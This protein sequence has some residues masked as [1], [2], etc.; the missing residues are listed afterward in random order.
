MVSSYLYDPLVLDIYHIF[1]VISTTLDENFK[2]LRVML[3]PNCYG[4]KDWTSLVEK[5]HYKLL[6]WAHSWL[7]LGGNLTLVQAVL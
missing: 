4:I 7:C 2:Y 5:I 6:S 1:G 3:Q